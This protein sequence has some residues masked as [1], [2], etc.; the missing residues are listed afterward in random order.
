M[1]FSKFIPVDGDFDFRS[2]ERIISGNFTKARV[3]ALLRFSRRFTSRSLN[4]GHE[5]DCCGCLSSRQVNVEFSN[6]S[7]K[8]ARITLVEHFNF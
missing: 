8:Y 7:Y 1:N 5:F 4:C 2:Y 6:G 3:K